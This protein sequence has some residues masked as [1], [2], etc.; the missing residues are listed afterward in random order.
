MWETHSANYYKAAISN[1]DKNLNAY[2]NSL[3]QYDNGRNPYLPIVHPE[4]YT[5]DELDENSGHGL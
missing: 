1:L 2:G 4:V 5:S 3:S